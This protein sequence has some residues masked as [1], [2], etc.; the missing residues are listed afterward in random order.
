MG[1]PL[2]IHTVQLNRHMRITR[3]Q[4]SESTTPFWAGVLVWALEYMDRCISWYHLVHTLDGL[5]SVGT[6]V[7]QG[8]AYWTFSVCHPRD[9]KLRSIITRTQFSNISLADWLPELA[10]L[11]ACT[12][13]RMICSA[14]PSPSRSALVGKNVE[15]HRLVREYL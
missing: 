13:H 12:A 8:D 14:S 2:Q 1:E 9:R 7:T 6:A 15:Q 3:R 11:M 5:S 10:N 4:W